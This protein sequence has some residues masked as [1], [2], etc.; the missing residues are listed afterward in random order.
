MGNAEMILK[1]VMSSIES[2]TDF[3]KHCRMHLP[4]LQSSEFQKI[5]DMKVKFTHRK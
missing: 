5:L 4:D 2:A 1:I 3:V